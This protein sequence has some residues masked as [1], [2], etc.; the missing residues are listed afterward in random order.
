MLPNNVVDAVSVLARGER[1][2]EEKRKML[3][4]ALQDWLEIYQVEGACGGIQAPTRDSAE[5]ND[6]ILA[7]VP[8]C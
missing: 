3:V 5:P 1:G 2:A 6:S 7:P 8:A 4:E